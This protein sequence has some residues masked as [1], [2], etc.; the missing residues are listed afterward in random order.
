[1]ETTDTSD[2]TTETTDTSDTTTETTST[3]SESEISSTT[4]TSSLSGGELGAEGTPGVTPPAT[5]A[6]ASSVTTGSADGFRLVLLGLAT[7]LAVIL[8]L[9]PKGVTDRK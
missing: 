3:G 4:T 9:Q 1:T 7:I 8:L 5:D 6:V 2:T